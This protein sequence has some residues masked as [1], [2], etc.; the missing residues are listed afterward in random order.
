[1]DMNDALVTLTEEVYVPVFKKV[2]ADLGI[3][4]SNDGDLVRALEM[5]AV[6]GAA[7]QESRSS[8]IKSA[9]ETLMK[10]AGVTRDKEIS[11]KPVA[12][13]TGKVK[14]ALNAIK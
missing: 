10:A 1:M 8:T 12:P 6:L 7:E 2:A 3:D 13:V 5:V 11:N 4:L 9:H 14:D